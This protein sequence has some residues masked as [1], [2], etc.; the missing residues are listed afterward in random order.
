MQVAEQ[1]SNSYHPLF[2][3]HPFP[4]KIRLRVGLKNN[5][6][7]LF[8]FANGTGVG[9][10]SRARKFKNALT[11]GIVGAVGGIAAVETGS[12]IS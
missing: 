12:L 5:K 2:L 4:P 1:Y 9:S 8:R 11:A 7:T 3:F 6:F 10:V